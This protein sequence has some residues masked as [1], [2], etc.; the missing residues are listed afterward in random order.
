MASS[1]FDFVPQLVSPCPSLASGSSCGS[2]ASLDLTGRLRNGTGR[3]IKPQ[4]RDYLPCG[5][6]PG[7]NEVIVGRGRRV[8]NHNA[9]KVLRSLL[10]QEL[11][12][13][14]LAVRKHDKT[15]V[16]SRILGK[17]KAKTDIGWGFVKRESATNRWFAVT[18]VV[19]RSTIAQ[20]FRDSLSEFYRSSR[21]AKLC[22]RKQGQQQRMKC[23]EERT[24][25]TLP[26]ALELAP[27]LEQ[28]P[29]TSE[30]KDKKHVE[31]KAGT[32]GE[33]KA[34]FTALFLAFGY[35]HEDGDPFEPTPI[36]PYLCQE[37][38]RSA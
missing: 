37:T 29:L 34:V 26:G 5:Y 33:D 6:T 13:Y 11:P 25:T 20:L 10:E 15:Q 2:L 27:S 36:L 12:A 21:Q 8:S 16:I 3:Y 19:A 23:A 4:D 35:K 7:P 31:M 9:N 38:A 28:P 17:I 32:T 22:R 30:L 18:E 14:T 24:D 1:K